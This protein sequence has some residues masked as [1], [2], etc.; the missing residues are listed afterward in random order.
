ETDVP[1]SSPLDEQPLTWRLM[2]LLGQLDD[3]PVY[4]PLLR[5]LQGDTDLR[6]RF[7]LAQRLADLFDQYQVYRADWLADW[8]AGHD[9][10]AGP[11]RPRPLEDDQQWQAALWRDILADVGPQGAAVGRAAVHARFLQALRQWPQSGHAPDLPRR[12]VVFGV[13]SLPRQSL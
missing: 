2:R 11:G 4:Q 8:A 5:F 10:L 1:E 12:I 6:R 13:S 7:Q 9:H 3:Q